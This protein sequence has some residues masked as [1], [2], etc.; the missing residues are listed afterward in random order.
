[1]L[2]TRVAAEA[3]VDDRLRR[4]RDFQSLLAGSSVSMLGSRLTAIGLPLLVLAVTGSPLVAGWAGFAAAAP[5]ILVLLPAGALVDRWNSR[6]AMTFSE[7][8]RGVAI[9]AVVVVVLLG[10]PSVEILIGLVVVEEVLGVFSALSERRIIC[11]L[12]EPDN[13]AS[14]LASAEARTHMVVLAGRSLGAFLFGLGQALP[15]LADALSFGVSAS[16]LM[17]IG[18]RQEPPQPAEIAERNLWR[19]IGDGLRW[20]RSDQFARIAFPLTACATLIG[21]ALIMVF[22]A[23]AHARDLPSAQIGMVL[24]A[25]GA[26][27]ALGSATAYWLFQHFQYRLLH[28]QMWIWTGMFALLAWSGG[29]SIFLM[30]V[31]L[32]V[33]GFAGALGNIALDT[34]LLRKVDVNMLGRATSIDRLTTFGGL[35]LGPLLGGAIAERNGV[36]QS[37]FALFVAAALLTAATAVASR[38]ARRGGSPRRAGS[39]TTA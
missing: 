27:G 29:K 17:R 30:A 14:A 25:S 24:A 21:Q 7:L 18:Q 10:R 11:S 3:P 16:V 32:T 37:I 23:E 19:E 13:T 28:I 2:V 36:A 12:V 38:R 1:M 5:S 4:K 33:T 22:L 6:R 31:A 9:A 35:A 26:G 39:R 8:G 20:V 15:F 34:Y